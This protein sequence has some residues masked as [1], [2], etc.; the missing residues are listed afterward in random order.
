[1]IMKSHQNRIELVTR[2][3]RLKVELEKIKK[4][5]S[6]TITELEMSL[7]AANKANNGLQNAGKAQ[8]TK[9]MELTSILEKTNQKLVMAT[10]AADGNAKRLA[11]AD[12]VIHI[13]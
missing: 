2:P 4:K 5:M 12:Q 13:L 8:A 9:I 3:D 1:M 11:V 10:E 7:D 6:V